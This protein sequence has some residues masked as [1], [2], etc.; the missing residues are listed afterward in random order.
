MVPHCPH[1][2]TGGCPLSWTMWTSGTAPVDVF[3]AVR[4]A[5]CPFWGT[6]SGVF[7]FVGKGRGPTGWGLPC[8]QW[9][10][11][12]P[13]SNPRKPASLLRLEGT[14]RPDRHGPEVEFP[15]V[16]RA[17]RPDWL[18]GPEAVALWDELFALLS[19]V[20]L[21]SKAD[22]LALGTLCNLHATC[23]KLYRAGMEPTAAQLTQLRLYMVEF[24]MTPAS[25]SK[26]SPVGGSEKE[27]PF[28]RFV[29]K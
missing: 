10:G 21:L 24:G 15:A 20:R 4:W 22:K 18:V 6:L 9:D 3:R 28:K 19:G 11:S 8:P 25:R 13:M 23:V 16:D 1:Q 29:S 26:A 2:R 17:D 12:P 14:H 5:F 7:G 27:N